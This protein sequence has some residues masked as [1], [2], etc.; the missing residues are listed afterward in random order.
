MKSIIRIVPLFLMMLLSV[1]VFSKIRPT[2]A[3]YIEADFR[4]TRTQALFDVP[5]T[6]TGK[7]TYTA[8]DIVT[9]KYD[10]GIEAELPKEMLRFISKAVSGEYLKNN[11]EF[12]VEQNGD[13]AILTPKKRQIKQFFKEIQIVFN[14][15]TGF[16]REVL[17]V[18]A[19]D[20][21]TKIEFFNMDTK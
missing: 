15:L 2:H 16:A 20:D 10:N 5:Q 19:T 21:V 4:Q 1:Q 17:M 7:F 18:E 9:W 13:V 14:P 11:T 12:D 6:M 3:S 8:P